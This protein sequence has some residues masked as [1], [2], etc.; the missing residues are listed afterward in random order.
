[1][2][3]D[4]AATEP[5]EDIVKLPLYEAKAAPDIY[6][7]G[8]DLDEDEARGDSGEHPNDDAGWFFVLKE[9]PGDPRFGLDI[10]REGKLQVWNDLAWPDVLTGPPSGAP[11]YLKLDASTP[12]LALEAPTTP[13]NV[14]AEQYTED[15]DILWSAQIGAGD[16]AY[17]LYQ[18]PVLVAVHARRCSAMAEPHTRRVE[19]AVAPIPGNLSDAY[20]MLLGPVRLETV[21]TPTE[22][23]VRVFPD[24]WAVDAFEP[25][26]TDHEHELA[27]GYWRKV[28]QAGGDRALRLS[29]WRDLVN[30]AGAGRAKWIA[31]NRKPLNPQDEPHRIGP[32]HV[33]LV[34]ADDDPLP[35]ADRPPART[36]WTAIY[37]AAGAKAAVQAAD[38]ALQSAVGSTRATRIRARRPAGMSQVPP[39]GVATAQVTVAFL[40]MPQAQ[41]GQTKGSSWTVAA[42]ARLLPDRFTLLGYAGGQL[43]VNV[44]GNAVPDELAV[45]P[46]PRRRR[47]TSCEHRTVT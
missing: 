41:A 14:K 6:F 43:V 32:D 12:A 40:D 20:P 8:F 10:N 29:A 44:T 9:R 33:I 47:P 2:D 38:S 36:Y 34:I 13:G 16:L 15:K 37:R 28:W 1:M 5:S 39:G 25:K 31:D 26:R 21:F 18:A 11:R 17:I 23:L 19:Q 3:L 35:A 46:D 45:S 22:L 7:F 30:S 27:F 4:P 24:E 42:K